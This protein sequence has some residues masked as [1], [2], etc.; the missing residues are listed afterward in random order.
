MPN[1][2]AQHLADLISTPL[3]QLIVALGS[4]IGRSQAELNRHSI[5][6]QRQIDEDPVLSQYGLQATWYQI[7][8]T[9]LD[10]KVAVAMQEHPDPQAP[11]A[12]AVPAG[13]IRGIGPLL[14]VP[15]LWLQPVN[16]LYTN[17]FNY[18]V[19]ASSTVTL[20]IVAVPPP[21]Q[22]AAGTPTMAEAD[23]LAASLPDL[24]TTGTPPAPDPA[25]RL[26]VNY[27]AGAQAWY[28]VQ[29]REVDGEMTLVR[30]VKIDDRTGQVVKTMAES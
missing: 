28:V 1:G 13:G 8:T 16:A 24:V 10:L 4:G 9:Q 25:L 29:T 20:S 17:R 18:D 30:L 12:P 19:N 6:T 11:A 26:T 15:R 7:P 22:A 21:G 5:E 3:E 27:N 23:V 2:D 14:A